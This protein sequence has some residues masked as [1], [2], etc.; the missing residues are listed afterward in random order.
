MRF[1]NGEHAFN[2][3]LYYLLYE[4]V[5]KETHLSGLQ[6]PHLADEKL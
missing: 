4:Q 3:Q 6:F 1:G 2:F 5:N